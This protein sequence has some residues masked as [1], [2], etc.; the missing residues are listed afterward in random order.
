MRNQ[1]NKSNLFSFLRLVFLIVFTFVI[2]DIFA[3]I[4]PRKIESI[5]FEMIGNYVVISVRVND[6]S[7]LNLILDS[8]IRNTMITELQEGDRVS[9]N[10]SD[11]KDMMG[12]G[13]GNKVEAYSSDYNTLKIGKIKI[14]NKTVFVFKE[15]TFNLSKHSGKKINGLIGSDL[16]LDYT[17]EID[18]GARRVRFY[19]PSPFDAPKGYG[20]LPLHIENQ[21]LFVELSVLQAANNRKQVK[22]LID[23]GAELNAW[24]QTF[25]K[26]SVSLPTK[27]IQGTIGVGLN[28]II[29]GKYGRIPEICFGGFCLKNPIVSFPDSASIK[30][31][32]TDAKRDGSI[33]SQLLSRFNLFI[34]FTQKKFYF[35]PNENFKNR[36]SYNVAGIEIIQ[37]ANNIPIAEVMSVWENSPAHK[38]GVQ[39][40]DKVLNINGNTAFAMP[41]SEIRKIFE[42]P[43]PIPL[44]LTLQRDEKELSISIDMKDRM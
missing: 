35:K 41:I 24:F 25:T 16:F 38:A 4:K 26:E 42:T 21:K 14:P 28:G 1:Q 44:N 11:V 32:V 13:G 10:Y 2:T 43:S 5:P 30:A 22:M 37:L 27:W 19:E 15:N 36:F 39:V 34:D 12:L 7:P 20:E 3:A 31:I 17:V 40:G 23:T 8:G 9:I 29:T 18:Y 6:S 33:G